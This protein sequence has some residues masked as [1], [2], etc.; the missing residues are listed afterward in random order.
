MGLRNVSNECKKEALNIFKQ[1]NKIIK[2]LGGCP[3]EEDRVKGYT[4]CFHCDECWIAALEK[5]IKLME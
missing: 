5:N 4:N 1:R 3:A 2:E